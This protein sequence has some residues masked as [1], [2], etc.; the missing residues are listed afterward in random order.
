MSDISAKREEAKSAQ[1][2][3]IWSGPSTFLMAL[4]LGYMFYHISV[5]RI[6]IQKSCLG[7]FSINLAYNYFF[8]TNSKY[9]R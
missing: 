6:Y 9:T 5:C 8:P 7:Q 4:G 2:R 3:R 1:P